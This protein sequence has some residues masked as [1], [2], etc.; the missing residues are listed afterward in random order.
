MTAKKVKISLCSLTPFISAPGI[1]FDENNNIIEEVDSP[2]TTIGSGLKK[3]R[4][5][6]WESLVRW[7]K[8]N[9]ILHAFIEDECEWLAELFPEVRSITAV[10]LTSCVFLPDVIRLSRYRKFPVNMG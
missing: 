4:S 8:E 9:E 2:K 7:E 1:E 10:L 6:S 3:L 5:N